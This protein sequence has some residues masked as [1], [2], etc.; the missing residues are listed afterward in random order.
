LGT[1]DDVERSS[2]IAMQYTELGRPPILDR[3]E[4]Q[5]D[6]GVKNTLRYFK[7]WRTVKF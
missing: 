5:H 1:S 6:V 4:Y 2:D 7:Y 3:C